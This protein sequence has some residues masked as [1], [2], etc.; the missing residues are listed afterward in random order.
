MNT[1]NTDEK[2]INDA[3]YESSLSDKNTALEEKKENVTKRT[4]EKPISSE[5]KVV[6]PALNKDK[7]PQPTKTGIEVNRLKRSLKP[8]RYTEPGHDTEP[9]VEKRPKMSLPIVVKPIAS[10]EKESGQLKDIEQDWMVIQESLKE[11]GNKAKPTEA[12]KQAPIKAFHITG[13]KD[14][15]VCMNNSLLN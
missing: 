9:L 10:T 6:H 13:D 12:Q 15:E 7:A 2:A 14:S 5:D 3:I 8:V 1:F 11:G 4:K